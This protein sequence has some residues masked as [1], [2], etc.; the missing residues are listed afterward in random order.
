MLDDL[1]AVVAELETHTKQAIALACQ[2]TRH[3]ETADDHQ[4]V[5]ERLAN[6]ATETRAAVAMLAAAAQAPTTVAAA[7]IAIAELAQRA[8][9]KLDGIALELGQ[10]E[11][12]ALALVHGQ[13]I[14][15]HLRTDAVQALGRATIGNNG[16]TVWP[17]DEMLS[18]VRSSVR[19]FAER[20][21]APHAAHPSLR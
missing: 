13:T 6:A 5:V 20:E 18:E 17:L 1:R 12:F 7:G 21:V 10:P 16:R 4:V 8:I 19:Q 15:Q 11:G 9:A 14:R 2:L 3:G